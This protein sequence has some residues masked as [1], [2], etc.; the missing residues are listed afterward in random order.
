VGS[1][2][3]SGQA[4]WNV[5]RDLS[6]PGYET[7]AAFATQVEQVTGRNGSEVFA[8]FDCA[9]AHAWL[10]LPQCDMQVRVPNHE[11]IRFRLAKQVPEHLSL[12]VELRPSP[13]TMNPDDSFASVVF[14]VSD[15][16]Q[17][18]QQT[19]TPL[20]DDSWLLHHWEA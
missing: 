20:S 18:C 9:R 4:E 1:A 19:P 2:A 11:L 5:L 13:W 16:Q 14:R 8:A 12:P 6:L 3:Y 15:C 7:Y 17:D 10:D